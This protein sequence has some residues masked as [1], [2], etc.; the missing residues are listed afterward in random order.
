MSPRLYKF[1]HN[2]K[3]KIPA[4]IPH[5][6]PRHFL[7]R[8]KTAFEKLL[9]APFNPN[10]LKEPSWRKNSVDKEKTS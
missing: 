10:S 4:G 3:R 9:E 5:S 8:T 2:C 6:H 7:T 1:C